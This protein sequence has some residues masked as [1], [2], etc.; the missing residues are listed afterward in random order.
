MSRPNTLRAFS[1]FS[2]LA[3]AAN[4]HAQEWTKHFRIGMSLGMNI[5]TD[6]SS[7]GTFP[8]SGTAVGAATP[9]QNHTY[10]D[11]FVRLDDTGNAVPFDST[12]GNGVTSNF[13][14]RNSAQYNAA[15]ET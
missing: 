12:T 9:G 14:Y 11:G 3:L 1:C 15:A 13:G 4:A 6:F 10:D 2:L 8:V 5:K 7:S